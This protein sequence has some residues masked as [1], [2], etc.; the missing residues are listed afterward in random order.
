MDFLDKFK[1]KTN[2]L[3]RQHV[4]GLL[5]KGTGSLHNVDQSALRIKERLRHRLLFLPYLIKISPA[6]FLVSKARTI[7]K[8]CHKLKRIEFLH[9]M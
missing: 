9:I 4:T 7:T 1:G 6:M 5:G 2:T 3:S 8:I